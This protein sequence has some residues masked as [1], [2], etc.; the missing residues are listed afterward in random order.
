MTHV[1]AFDPAT[2]STSVTATL[3]V[4]GLFLLGLVSPGP[5]F[6]VVVDSTLSYGRRA[7]IVTGLGAAIGDAIYASAGLFGLSLMI[8]RGGYFLALIKVCGGV[9]L[10]WLGLKMI[11]RRGSL[12][13]AAV[14][15]RKGS[16]SLL[17][18]LMRGLASD[19]SNPKTIAF[20][21]S[22]F[23][24]A[25]HAGTP[26]VVRVVM[27]VGIFVTS[28]LWRSL[29]SVVFSTPLVRTLYQRSER[30]MEPIFG[31]ILCVLGLRLVREAL[32]LLS[33]RVARFSLAA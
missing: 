30:V 15:E 23:A 27:L 19:L 31:A 21:A 4:I 11:A 8:S 17:R 33:N 18:L 20:F 28:L 9:Y 1:A 26:G 14:L 13:N 5:N 7:G 32:R 25:V 16:A 12:A 6:L 10:A 3:S 22:I 29:L 2:L 24:L